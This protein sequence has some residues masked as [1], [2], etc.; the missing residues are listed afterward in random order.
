MRQDQHPATI[1]DAFH[2]GSAFYVVARLNAHG[3]RY[4]FRGRPGGKWVEVIENPATGRYRMLHGGVGLRLDQ[5]E[6]AP[7]GRRH[8]RSL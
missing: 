2:K 7:P 5:A 8:A 4:V 6:T 3:T 1:V